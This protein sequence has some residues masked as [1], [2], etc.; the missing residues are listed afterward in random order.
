M[1]I[2]GSTM[3]ALGDWLRRKYL[4]PYMELGI[5]GMTNSYFGYADI[6]V[7]R[8]CQRRIFLFEKMIPT[9][10]SVA[11]VIVSLV[12]SHADNNALSVWSDNRPNPFFRFYTT[13]YKC[14]YLGED[15]IT[16]LDNH[17]VLP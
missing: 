8:H 3:P 17:L 9:K 14:G 15:S 7:H 11:C 1:R 16:R 12:Y 6:V 2:N 5:W 13:N 4:R 10:S